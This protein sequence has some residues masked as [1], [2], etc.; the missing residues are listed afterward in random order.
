MTDGQVHSEAQSANYL[1]G[2]I[3]PVSWMAKIDFINHLIL[4][5]NVLIAAL[6]EH[7]GGKTTFSSLLLSKLDPQIKSVTMIA[8]P[9]CD[10]EQILQKIA[11]QLHLN[12]DSR[13]TVASIVAQ[14]NDRKSHVLLLI[15]DAQHLPES[16]IKQFLMEIK[17][18][19]SLGFFH[20]CLVSDFSLVATLNQLAADQ[21]SNMIHS[22]ELGVLSESET[23]IYLT[24]RAV[25]DLLIEKP[26]T[27][28]Q[29][30]SFYELTKGSIAKM[31]SSLE[32]FLLKTYSQKKKMR[33]PILKKVG[34]AISAVVVSGLS[35]F[36]MGDFQSKPTAPKISPPK[37]L[38]QHAVKHAVKHAQYALNSQPLISYVASLHDAST[39]QLVHHE[40]PKMQ[41]LDDLAREQG[42]VNTVAVVDK[43]IVIPSIKKA[44]IALAKA[45]PKAAP[46]LKSKLV[47]VAGFKA[48]QSIQKIN[49][50]T[51]DGLY[52]IQLV[53]SHKISVINR[54]KSSNKL[55]A[56]AKIRHF[57]NA[58]GSWYILTL[59]E[60]E[61][62]A[63]A[64]VHAKKLPAR[65]AK[66]NPWVRAV[67]GL[68]KI[69]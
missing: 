55:L 43:V 1:K 5:N 6:A 59:G 56:S 33:H 60:F 51:R 13:T 8:K 25:T 42:N 20:L 35:Y 37:P 68:P 50:Q 4:F 39:L 47:K 7:G 63:Q 21:F 66:L 18:Q 9:P 54:V 15:D 48:K 36:Y 69:G 30:K 49:R 41:I 44:T 61:N 65:I 28:A 17:H 23:K 31:N 27:Q 10:E 29:F 19:D 32:S 46:V 38:V 67:S 45:K 22:I 64:Q 11:T 52:T 58:K 40:L 53:A 14:I 26:L 3:K 24:Q 57:N 16:V 2:L 12:V 62:R 34:M